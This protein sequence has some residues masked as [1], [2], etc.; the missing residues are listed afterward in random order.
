MPNEASFTKIKKIVSSLEGKLEISE[1]FNI[2]GGLSSLA[3]EDKKVLKQE[4][5]RLKSIE[6]YEEEAKNNGFSLI[7]GVDE[8]GRGP[9]A[10]PVVAAAAIF[11]RNPMI[12]G[13]KDSK[14]L[15]S[16][17]RE[18]L[19]AY[20]KEKSL[21]WSCSVVPV[22]FINRYNIMKASYAA[23]KEA[24]EGLKVKPDFL[25]VDGNFTVPEIY[26]S[27]RAIVKGDLKSFSIAA[28]SIIAKVIRDSIM[29]NYHQQ[30][31]QYGFANNKGYGTKDHLEALRLHGPTPL[32]RNFSP[33]AALQCR[34]TEMW[35]EDQIN[36]AE[37]KSE[38]GESYG[39]EKRKK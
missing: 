22:D 38:K 6:K 28:A 30:F 32:H 27:Q 18:E 19:F 5:K 34:Q 33:V 35:D 24:V 17:E 39:K 3:P 29:D 36:F 25:M 31:P 9:L 12:P 37:V 8:A 10:G 23:M 21:S 14:L 13:V 7:A 11:D 2:A 1:I 4:E 20:V 26:I 16:H 15:K